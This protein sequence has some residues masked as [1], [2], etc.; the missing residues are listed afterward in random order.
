MEKDTLLGRVKISEGEGLTYTKNGKTVAEISIEKSLFPHINALLEKGKLESPKYSYLELLLGP[1]SEFKSSKINIDQFDDMVKSEID[2]NNDGIIDYSCLITGKDVEIETNE[3]KL[4]FILNNG[5]AERVTLKK[6]GKEYITKLNISKSYRKSF[7]DF[8]N[9]YKNNKISL[10]EVLDGPIEESSISSKSLEELKT[11]IN[12]NHKEIK[13]LY[14]TVLKNQNQLMNLVKV[15]KD[16]NLEQKLNQI[17]SKIGTLNNILPKLDSLYDNQSIL[18]E[19]VK[20][21]E[22]KKI[23][24]KLLKQLYKK[25]SKNNIL[26]NNLEKSFYKNYPQTHVIASTQQNKPAQNSYLPF[27]WTSIGVASAFLLYALYTLVKPKPNFILQNNSS[28]RFEEFP[29]PIPNFHSDLIEKRLYRDMHALIMKY[30]NNKQFPNDENK[31][32]ILNH[33]ENMLPSTLPN[34]FKEIKPS[35]FYEESRFSYFEPNDY[36]LFIAQ[37]KNI[38]KQKVIDFFM[39]HSIG[40]YKHEIVS[41]TED[42]LLKN[43]LNPLLEYEIGVLFPEENNILIIDDIGGAGIDLEEKIRKVET[44]VENYEP[45]DQGREIDEEIGEEIE[46]EL[47]E[48]TEN[49]NESKNEDYQNS[50]SKDISP[51]QKTMLPSKVD[52]V[53]NQKT[54]KFEDQIGVSSEPTIEDKLETPANETI[55]ENF[56]PAVASEEIE[57]TFNQYEENRKIN[58]GKPIVK[59]QIELPKSEDEIRN[60]YADY[61]V[62]LFKEFKRN[63][64]KEGDIAIMTYENIGN[65]WKNNKL[66]TEIFAKEVN[67]EVCYNIM[68]SIW[69]Y[70]EKDYKL[71]IDDL[72]Y[73]VKKNYDL[74]VAN[75]QIDYIKQ[76]YPKYLSRID[77]LLYSKDVCGSINSLFNKE[78]YKSFILEYSQ[79]MRSLFILK[80]F[81][82]FKDFNEITKRQQGKPISKELF[83][84]FSDYSAD[85]FYK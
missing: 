18:L 16:T 1:Y 27:F 7:S 37:R 84:G 67:K 63:L 79:F 77:P 51:N 50:D 30:V 60:I 6:G 52:D 17:N 73:N 40:E 31:S 80:D 28:P 61:F 68:N 53:L 42:Y 45:I 83:K 2:I 39:M 46:D 75:S 48:Y 41:I 38:L 22:T 49:H 21:L 78:D 4:N 10:E 82:K 23:D 29:K 74:S 59:K 72:N 34:L 33:I 71:L 32:S 20:K 15:K 47:E 58:P 69:V 9:N 85:Y 25:I 43:Y 56:N 36:E 26:I 55:I 66:D 81:F 11:N 14:Q 57:E 12:K 3:Y 5:K 19:K 54:G 13:S 24:G 65:I 8:I 62:N 44:S 64:G 70:S 76:Y 35:K